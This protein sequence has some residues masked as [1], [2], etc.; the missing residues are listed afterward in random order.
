MGH[1]D[2]GHGNYVLT[3]LMKHV[4][5]PI[6]MAAS[7]LCAPL[8]HAQDATI[9]A[10]SS[11][12]AT[13]AAPKPVPM[14]S[15]QVQ[16]AGERVLLATE[17]YNAG[18]AALNGGRWQDAITNLERALSLSP[19]DA[20]AQKLRGYAYLKLGRN[21][22]ALSALR[23][24]ER[25]QT[26]LETGSRS[27]VQNYIGLALWNNR[28]YSLSLAAYRNA[29]KINSANEEAR[30]NLAFA[31]LSIKQ[32]RESISQFTQLIAKTPRDASLHHG[33]G[34]AYE[35]LG[36]WPKAIAAYRL[37][38]TNAPNEYSYQ[39]ALGLALVK[40]DP[41]G[42][43][44]N[45]W[46]SAVAPLRAASSLAPNES[47][48]WLQMGLIYLN[49]KRW[50]E[51]Q[52]AFQRYAALNPTNFSGLFNLALSFD[53]AGKFDEA[54]SAY[55][56]ASQVQPQSAAVQNNIGRVYFKRRDNERA[57]TYFR[58]A[59]GLDATFL[60]AR[61]NLAIA[62]GARG[63]DKA[64]AT[65]W[66]KLIDSANATL[67]GIPTT[68][69]TSAQKAQRAQIQNRVL[70][71][72]AVLAE[73]FLKNNQH[74][75]AAKQYREVMRLNPSN[76]AAQINLGL[77]LYYLRDY[78]GALSTYDAILKREPNNAVAYNNRGVVLEAQKNKVA[79]FAAYK[80]AIEL[81]PDYTDAKNNRDRLLSST[82]IS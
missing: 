70:A 25:G 46:E 65:E 61:N 39:L 76:S 51:A 24:A 16:D 57:I 5:L 72:R 71:A 22:D 49:R 63:D 17:A 56:K 38:V 27:D 82:S 69:A 14:P 21:G 28:E 81:R 79:A 35:S 43:I 23:L 19:D 26:Q 13:V 58:A 41:N 60:D 4:S 34:R 68:G 15:P 6:L 55:G 10:T 29:L 66:Q 52:N 9:P 30:Y 31:L 11:A 64:A 1:S 2:S 37:A 62:L 33:L 50:T 3:K 48:A 32:A 75:E 78:A 80:R 42:T 7:V 54:L 12:P 45:R 53:S 59:L 73:G 18:V 47:G 67:R 77:S 74:A 44:K 40:S 36:N 8:L 20:T